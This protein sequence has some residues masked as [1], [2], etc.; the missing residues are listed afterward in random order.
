VPASTSRFNFM[1]QAGAGFVFNA[2]GRM[3]VFAG[4]RF[5]HISN[6]GY[7]PRNPG[8]NVSTVVVG[9]QLRSAMLRRR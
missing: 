7:A 8:L 5:V 6:G 3:P 9:L 2:A 4:Y 1:S